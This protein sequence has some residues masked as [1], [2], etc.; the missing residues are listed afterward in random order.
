[1]AKEFQLNM[2][3]AHYDRCYFY[4]SWYGKDHSLY[5]GIAQHG[6]EGDEP[7]MDVTVH[8]DD[9]LPNDCIA[10]K[11]YSENKGLLEKLKALGLVTKVLAYGPC[12]RVTVPVCE[13]D[14]AVLTQYGSYA[15]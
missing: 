9:P 4:T 11:N 12:G 14:K 7:L 1:M 5:I 13:Y 2:G 3:Y 10:V 15:V 6:S 8:L